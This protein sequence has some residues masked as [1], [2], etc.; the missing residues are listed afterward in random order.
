MHTTHS[1]GVEMNSNRPTRPFLR[2]VG[3]VEDFA[4]GA[5]R[6]DKTLV[7]THQATLPDRCAVCNAPAEG[8][9]VKKT[10]FWHTPMLLPLL[11]LFPIGIIIYGVLAALFKKTMPVSMP[12]CTKH[13][14]RRTI[15]GITGLL[16]LPAFPI[17]AAVGLS[18]SEPMLIPPGIL[19]SLA[20]I[21]VLII[22]RNEL[23]PTRITETYAYIRGANAEWLDTLP[24]WVDPER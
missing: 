18:I 9:T 24:Q 14:R 19:L 4:H 23:W 17:F 3:E 1:S 16:M 6:D 21:V 10:L 7:I 5:W 15:I 22:G 20:G 13:Q 12:L 2:L 8:T 11:V